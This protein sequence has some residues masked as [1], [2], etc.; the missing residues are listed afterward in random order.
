MRKRKPT[1]VERSERT[2]YAWIIFLIFLFLLW[3][4]GDKPIFTNVEMTE[5]PSGQYIPWRQ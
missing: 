4:N 1:P 2:M 5:L 3:A